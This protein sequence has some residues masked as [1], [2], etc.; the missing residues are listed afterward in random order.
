MSRVLRKN[1]VSFWLTLPLHVPVSITPRSSLWLRTL[2]CLPFR[3]SI[4][5][6]EFAEAERGQFLMARGVRQGCPL[7]GFLF[8]MAFDPSF[9]SLQESTIP[10]NPDNLEFLQPAQCAYADDLAVAS[11]SFRGL[12]TALAPASRSVDYI[13]GLDLNYRKCCWVQCGTEERESLRTWISENCEG[14]REM[15]IVRHAKYVGTMI[16]PDGYLHRWSAP[17][18]N[19]YNSCWKSMLLP[20]AWL[21]D[22]VT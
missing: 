20:R 5:H 21:S 2:D 4:T 10:R 14:F 19:S 17:R 12:M 13:A 18:K 8:A 6:V 22:C 11:L 3:D 16:G 9:R 15:Q 1:Q 7:S